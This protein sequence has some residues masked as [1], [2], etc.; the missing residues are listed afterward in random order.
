MQLFTAIELA[1]VLAAAREGQ[2]ITPEQQARWRLTK[3]R[4]ALRQAQARYEKTAKGRA[5]RKRY[6]G[7]QKHLD[8]NARY[9]RSAHGKHKVAALNSRRIF[10][11]HAYRGRAQTV[12]QADAIRSH[13]KER[14]R[15]FIQGQQARAQMEA[16]AADA[17]S[18]QAGS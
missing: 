12:E 16:L 17:V 10:L 6:N 9:R 1:E 18:V 2:P 11:G 13:I 14:T 7:S 15:A 8:T 4:I 3:K 5:V